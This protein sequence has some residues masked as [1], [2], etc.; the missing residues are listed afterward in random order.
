L[1]KLEKIKSEG[2]DNQVFN[3]IYRVLKDE[4]VLLNINMVYARSILRI[5]NSETNP[6]LQNLDG[7]TYY[8]NKKYFD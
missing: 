8:S 4:L 2:K 6:N 1:Q 3:N 7:P 5:L